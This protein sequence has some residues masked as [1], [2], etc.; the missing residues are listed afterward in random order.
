[1]G[2]FL[3]QFHNLK[4]G[5]LRLTGLSPEQLHIHLGLAIFLLAALLTKRGL[6]SRLPILIVVAAEVINE[7]LDRL[8]HGSWR[9]TN[10]GP[11]LANS[12]VWPLAIYL[13]AR[14]RQRG[15]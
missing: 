12:L 11:D 1:M 8:L 10:T 2:P 15:R 4:D 14:M 6:G 13:V 7:M 3:E 5:L 9:L